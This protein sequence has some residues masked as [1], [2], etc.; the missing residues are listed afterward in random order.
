MKNWILDA[1]WLLTA[2]GLAILSG[3]ASLQLPK[4]TVYTNIPFFYNSGITVRNS[5]GAGVVLI[6]QSRS[7]GFVAE[8]KLGKRMWQSL[9]LFHEKIPTKLVQL[10]HGETFTIPLYR[11]L[12]DRTVYIPFAVKVVEKGKVL[13]SYSYCVSAYPGQDNN[14]EFNFGPRELQALKEGYTGYSC[15]SGGYFY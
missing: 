9:W 2:I 5:A 13:G 14:L 8:Y 12:S 11:N 6:P 7:D 1:K 3:C 10:K 4:V 15:G